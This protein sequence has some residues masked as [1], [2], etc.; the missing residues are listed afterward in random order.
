MSLSLIF[1]KIGSVSLLSCSSEVSFT[2][3]VI[4]HNINQW[5]DKMPFHYTNKR[6]HVM[7]MIM[8][9]TTTMTMT[10]MTDTFV[11]LLL[12][13]SYRKCVSLR[14]KLKR[15][16]A[17]KTVSRSGI[18]C[19]EISRSELLLLLLL[20]DTSQMSCTLLIT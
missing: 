18:I 11:C 7:I 16:A 14:K 5:P 15:F 10:M 12:G 1:L 17:A 6:T 3:V 13:Q 2:L 8:M 4:R 19:A 20:F 9:A